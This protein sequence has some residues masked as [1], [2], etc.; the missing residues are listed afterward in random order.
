MTESGFGFG[1][2][3]GFDFGAEFGLHAGLGFGKTH[4]VLRSSV[5]TYGSGC[6]IELWDMDMGIEGNEGNEGTKERMRY[7]FM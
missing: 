5:S 4:G 7:G 3:F 1:F 2:R 6:V